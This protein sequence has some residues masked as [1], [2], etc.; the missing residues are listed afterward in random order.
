MVAGS[1]PAFPHGVVDPIGEIA[2]AA[3]AHGVW[4][5]VDACVGGHF[6]PF[7][8][9]LGADVPDWDFAVPGVTSIS[10]SSTRSRKL[11]SDMLP[12]AA[13]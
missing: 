13:V 7:A 8:R 5:H 12:H 11:Y 1:V 10:A 3:R 2:A 9:Q 4:M 6:A